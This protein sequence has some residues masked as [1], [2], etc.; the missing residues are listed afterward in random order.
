[1][2]KKTLLLILSLILALPSLA[3][4]QGGGGGITIQGMAAAAVQTTLFIASAI[5]VI[6]W[7]VTGLLFLTAQGAPEKLKT[8]RTS[9]FAAVAG[10]LLVIVAGSAIALV[11]QMFG[12]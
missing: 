8:A 2:N 9:L 6:L 12:I 7:I 11:G 4:A 3:S 5:V 1:M 10:T